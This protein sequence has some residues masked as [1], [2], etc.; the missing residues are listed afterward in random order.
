MSRSRIAGAGGRVGQHRNGP[1]QR[2]HVDVVGARIM[3]VEGRTANIGLRDDVG[4]PDLPPPP[5]SERDG[6]RP[7]IKAARVR[8]TRRSPVRHRCCF[9]TKR[10]VR[11]LADGGTA[12]VGSVAAR[13]LHDRG[14]PAG[15]ESGDG[16]SRGADRI[17]GGALIASAAAS[18][19]A[20]A[21]HPTEA[22]SGAHGRLRPRRDDRAADGDAFGFA[23][24][25]LRRG[26]GRPPILA[27]LVAYLVSTSP[28]SARRRSTASS[29]RRSP[30]AESPIASSSSSPGKRTRRWRGSA[31]SR[32]ARPISC[33]RI[34]FLGRPGLEAKAIG[35]L[36]LVAGLAPALLLGGRRDP[37]GRRRRLHRLC[38]VRR[39]GRFGRAA[40]GPGR[41]G[42][43]GRRLKVYQSYSSRP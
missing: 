26:A 17:A 12:A 3:F 33:G 35:A 42:G 32:P 37:D 9:R 8:V 16:G 29:S 15:R 7:A 24:F 21:H 23:H 39:L 27:G 22:H 2:R 6:R 43:F 5:D 4:D 28:M 19:L 31:S 10:L 1:R 34:D 40:P 20:M 13:H 36:G 30:R 14:S 38:R 18:V 25:A 11:P 41:A